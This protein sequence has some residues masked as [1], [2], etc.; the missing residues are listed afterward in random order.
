MHAQRKEEHLAICARRDVRSARTTGLERYHLV[1]QALPE[2]DYDS[3]DTSV[4]FLGHSLRAPVLISSMTGGTPAAQQVNERL[5]SAAQELGLAMALGS[6]RAAIEDARLECTYQVRRLAPDVL[7]FANLGAVQLNYGY[8]IDECRRAVESVG[9]D[10][11]VL[12]LNPLQEVLQPGGS[13]RFAGLLERIATICRNLAVPVIVKEVG[14]GISGDVARRLSDV[15]VA[16]ID[17]AGAGGT[18]WSEV[19]RLRCS[20][21]EDAEVASAFA[22]WGLPT[23]E[24]LEQVRQ[25]CPSLPL[26]AS[27]GIGTGVQVALC[28]A[29]GAN[30]AGMAGALLGP[31]LESSQSVLATLRA[32]VRQLRTAMFC[33]GAATVADLNAQRMVRQ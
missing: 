10:A 11:L 5:A 2:L 31:A 30:L 8:G 32:I 1:H 18:S 23:A 3:V 12:H 26:I 27:G 14:W 33:C 24:A 7:L 4:R 13:T 28:L 15:G 6:L 29:L 21:P 17:V 25:T 16:A 19:E 22:D 9:A 20:T